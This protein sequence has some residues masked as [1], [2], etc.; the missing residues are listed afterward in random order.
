MKKT[1]LYI[2]DEKC[3]RDDLAEEL[4]CHGF[5]VVTGVN[6]LDGLAKLSATVPDLV[7]TDLSMPMMSGYEFLAA[8]GGDES[9]VCRLPVILLSAYDE[10]E[11]ISKCTVK[12]RAILKKPVDYSELVSFVESFL[13][14]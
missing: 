9:G 3:L 14:T 8:I 5:D 6:G 12:P 13:S 2:E 10:S 1:I 11:I 4:I 7:I